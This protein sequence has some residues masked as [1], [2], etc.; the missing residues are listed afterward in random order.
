MKTSF[1]K[2]QRL[3]SMAALMT[4]IV[5]ALN[6]CSKDKDSSTPKYRIQYKATVTEGSSLTSVSYGYE[7]GYNKPIA[8]SGTSW[9]SDL[10][11]VPEGVIVSNIIIKGKGKDADARLEIEVYVN[12]KKV[13]TGASS[14][15]ELES[16]QS[17][18]FEWN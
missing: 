18:G 14:G 3:L 8:L 11:D 9:E 16:K 7:E 6:A 12:G 13:A 10:M 15:K 5:I 1:K 17:W 4:M 2:L